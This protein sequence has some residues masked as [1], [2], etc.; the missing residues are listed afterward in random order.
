MYKKFLYQFKLPLRPVAWARPANGKWGYYDTQSK[1]KRD[2]LYQFRKI[3]KGD[4]LTK[5]PLVISATYEYVI[6]KSWGKL[7]QKEAASGMYP[8]LAADIDNTLKFTFDLFNGV[9]WQDD[10]QIV[11]L[12]EVYQIYSVSDSF[13]IK[14][15]QRIL[16]DITEEQVD[17]FQGNVKN[18]FESDAAA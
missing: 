4:Y 2:Y 10:R 7:K 11:G 8:Y 9:I 1:I 14:V 13:S 5:E 18:H 6:P 12:N 15:Y 3:Y 17:M 16:P